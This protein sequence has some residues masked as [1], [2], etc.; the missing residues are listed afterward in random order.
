MLHAACCMLRGSVI[1]M[2]I[3]GVLGVLERKFNHHCFEMNSVTILFSL[4]RLSNAWVKKRT[5]ALKKILKCEYIFTFWCGQEPKR[6]QGN[7]FNELLIRNLYYKR[8]AA[9]TY[10]QTFIKQSLQ[11]R[12]KMLFQQFNMQTLTIIFWSMIVDRK[13]RRNVKMLSAWK[14]LRRFCSQCCIASIKRVAAAGRVSSNIEVGSVEAKRLN[15][16]LSNKIA[17]SIL[18]I[19]R[20]RLWVISFSVPY[21]SS[22]SILPLKRII[23]IS[24][25][26]LSMI[27]SP[28][29]VNNFSLPAL[30]FIC[31]SDRSLPYLTNTVETYFINLFL[32]AYTYI[33]QI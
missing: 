2:P 15:G 3:W 4:K 25:P 12:K 17:F 28:V 14:A 27:W 8:Q 16:M 24:P 23:Q 10:W 13:S 26:Y 32:P 18:S 31:I 9:L 7:C 1:F 33:I 21:P 11:R 22:Y 5:K 19:L 20:L 29:N 6:L 30:V